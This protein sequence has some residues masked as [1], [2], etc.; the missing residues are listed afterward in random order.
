MDKLGFIAGFAVLGAW[1]RYTQ[2]LLVQRFVGRGFPWA[3]LSINVFGSFLMG[4][5]YIATTHG[6]ANPDLRIGILVGGIGTYTTFSTF[7]LESLMLFE[8]GFP[9]KGLTY[10]LLSVTLGISATFVGTI[11]PRLIGA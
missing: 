9:A 10:M 2:T 1:A 4:F 5:L 3:T 7:T 6:H 8:D 11:A